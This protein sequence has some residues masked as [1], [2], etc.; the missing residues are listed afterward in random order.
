MEVISR[1]YASALFHP[2]IQLQ[3]YISQQDVWVPELLKT[4]LREK[5]QFLPGNQPWSSSLRRVTSMTALSRL[6]NGKQQENYE[7]CVAENKW[8]WRISESVSTKKHNV[9][10][11]SRS[12]QNI[13]NLRSDS[14]KKHIG[15]LR[16][17]S[18]QKHIGSLRSG[19]TQNITE[20]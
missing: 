2:D 5:S 12:I 17:G 13:G 8:P 7:Q 20:I 15:N 6:I 10:L 9:N 4:W 11:R 19:S 1:F 18:T 3:V 16:S 14:I